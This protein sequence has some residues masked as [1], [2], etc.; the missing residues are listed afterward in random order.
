MQDI[1]STAEAYN[2]RNAAYTLPW[3]S[4]TKDFSGCS[5][6]VHYCIAGHTHH[7][8]FGEYAGIPVI[9]TQNALNNHTQPTFD[10]IAFDHDT[11]IL[12]ANRI[13]HGAN[14]ILHCDHVAV[15]TT[16]TLTATITGTLTWV[17]LDETV[18]TV[19]DGTVTA[20]AS[21]YAL[22]AATNESGEMEGW[23]VAVS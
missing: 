6:T 9:I 12:Y 10:L 22:I 14:R 2:Q 18:A 8:L 21:G 7:D 17:S 11:E 4:E 1:L 13:G 5:G 16:E 3:V 15:S 19:S 20:V 23:V